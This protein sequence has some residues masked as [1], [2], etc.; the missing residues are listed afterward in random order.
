[1]NPVSPTTY[2]DV[3]FRALLLTA[4]LQVRVRDRHLRVAL[5]VPV[6][7]QPGDAYVLLWLLRA[8]F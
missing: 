1:M 7:R 8:L 2:G 3:E 6:C 5:A 4:N